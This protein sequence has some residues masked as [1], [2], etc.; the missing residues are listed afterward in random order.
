M[1]NLTASIRI[2]NKNSP[3]NKGKRWIYYSI[4]KES[5][6]LEFFDNKIRRREEESSQ[7]EKTDS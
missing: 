4:I 7:I 2:N 1:S 3:W 5:R 6:Y